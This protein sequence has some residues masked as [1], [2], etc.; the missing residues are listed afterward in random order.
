MTQI[1][2]IEDDKELGEILVEIL[3]ELTSSVQHIANGQLAI[4]TL[5]NTQPTIIYLDLHLPVISGIEILDIIRSHE[6]LNNTR[7]I[8]MTA[9]AIQADGLRSHV[10]DVLIK[11][12]T[13]DQVLEITEKYLR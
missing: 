11:P 13:L 10:D 7:V 8:L 9:D 3:T 6:H 5:S 2:V 4:Q 1:L 12:I